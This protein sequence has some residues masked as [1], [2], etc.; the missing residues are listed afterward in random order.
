MGLLTTED[1]VFKNCMFIMSF[2]DFLQVA[3]EEL[4]RECDYQLE[5]SNQKRF[6][7]LLSS[8]EGFYVPHVVDDISRKRVL[9]TELISG[10]YVVSFRFLFCLEHWVWIVWCHVL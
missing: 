8:R 2:L 1:S 4:S 7:D 10:N 3:K 6:R 9:T 5:A